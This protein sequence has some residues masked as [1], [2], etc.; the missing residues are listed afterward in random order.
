[1]RKVFL[2]DLPKKE[3]IGANKGREV[4]DWV[5]SIGCKVR[6]TYDDIEGEIELIDYNS[7]NRKLTIK[8]NDEIFC[9]YTNDFIHCKL[10][11][12]LGKFTCN[13][14]I[15]IGETFKS[16]IIMDREYR[17]DKNNV[18]WKWYQYNCSKCNYFGWISENNL[19]KG[20]GC[21]CC[22]PT[23]R[24]VVEGIN[25][26]TTTAPWMLDLGVDKEEAKQFTK[27]SSKKIKCTCPYCGEITHKKINFIYS[28]KSIG[29]ICGDGISYPEKFMYNVLKQLE[30]DF[31]SQYSPKYLNGKR[32]DFYVPSLNLII[33]MDGRLGHEGGITHSK[34][35]KTIKECIEVDKWKD[36]QHK[37][38]G[39]KTIRINCF[40][41]DMEYIK[42]SVLNSE[43]ADLLNMDNV[44]WLVCEEY[45]LNNLIKIVS[46]YWEN[47]DTHETAKDLG[48]C[49]NVSRKSIVNYLKKGNLLGWNNYNSKEEM[50]KSSK[51]NSELLSKKIS[52][53]VEVFKDGISLGIFKSITELSKQSSDLFGVS[54]VKSAICQICIGNYPSVYHKGYTFKYVENNNEELQG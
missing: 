4:I 7:K 9:I 5:G 31:E 33:E 18:V 38:H 43:L 53:E 34:S 42:N 3:G 54:F 19:M 36:K 23:P 41:S 10:G 39:V 48:I 44:S 28:K 11:K 37:L 13:F 2:D 24:V 6:F 46:E 40:K 1:M 45:A 30:V 29:C 50:I 21:S 35:E 12:I 49:F 8:C 47:R 25:D 16:L 15:Q 27:S 26:I 52:K 32:S 20:K 22:C 51:N 17:Q 14:K